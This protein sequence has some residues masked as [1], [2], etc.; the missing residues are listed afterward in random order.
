LD[1]GERDQALEQGLLIRLPP[2]L[3]QRALEKGPSPVIQPS[4]LHRIADLAQALRGLLSTGSM[5]GQDRIEDTIRGLFGH[6]GAIEHRGVSD[7]L[8]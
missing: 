3:R 6:V 8:G 7:E 1:A 4:R 5:P 2:G